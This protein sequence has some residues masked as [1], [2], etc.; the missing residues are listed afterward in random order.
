MV[1]RKRSEVG[2]L[3]AGLVLKFVDVPT[4]IL[5]VFPEERW[6]ELV[7]GTFLPIEAAWAFVFVDVP[8]T[9]TP[10]EV[11]RVRENLAGC[12]PRAVKERRAPR[13]AAIPQRVVARVTTAHH[14]IGV[15]QELLAA[16][17]VDEA[18][19]KRA[20]EIVVKELEGQGL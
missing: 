16:A 3:P 12:I 14:V 4:A 13:P 5:T 18:V 7:A 11:V 19:R 15:A 1:R 10:D 17:N 6:P 9:A 20:A 8:A 2:A